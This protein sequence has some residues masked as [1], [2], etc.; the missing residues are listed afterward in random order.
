MLFNGFYEQFQ[1]SFI[2]FYLWGD[3]ASPP[4]PK[5][6][7]VEGISVKKIIERPQRCHHISMQADTLLHRVQSKNVLQRGQAMVRV[8]ISLK[9]Q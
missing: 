6:K 3:T 9:L 8:F 2:S 7:R 1:I 5:P 4:P